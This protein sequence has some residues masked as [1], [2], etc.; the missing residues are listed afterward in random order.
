[1]LLHRIPGLA[2]RP[3]SS[4]TWRLAPARG[5]RGQ[6]ARRRAER[7]G[8]A[9]AAAGSAAPASSPGSGTD[10][11]SLSSTY[12]LLSSLITPPGDE[13]DGALTAGATPLGRG[14]IARRAVPAGA[15]LLT[16]ELWNALCIDDAGGAFGAR[17]LDDWQAVHGPLPPL[18][19]AYLRS[20][21]D[22]FLRLVAWLLYVARHGSGVWPLYRALLPAA[23]ESLMW[24]LPEERG[25]L[26]S[27]ELEELA[28]RVGALRLARRRSISLAVKW[29]CAPRV[30]AARCGKV[31][32][33]VDPRLTAPRAF[34]IDPQ[35]RSA[36]LRLH[37]TVFSEATGDLAALKLAA[38]PED[39]L[40]AA[41][42]VNSRCF[43]DE[44]RLGSAQ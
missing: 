30:C 12:D 5:A 17:A 34:S 24:F 8:P 14:L 43:A 38:V 3:N 1:M 41:S 10:A 2:H 15:P 37:D 13:A 6:S 7:S 32:P 23:H 25:E 31:P 35:E 36:I 9:W 44:V 20:G 42:M 21:S 19:D 39:T 28:A 18:L 26:Q 16:V 40:W 4:S 11:A 22:W 29:L 33:A 27:A